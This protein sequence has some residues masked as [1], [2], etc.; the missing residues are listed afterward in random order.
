MN[1]YCK[2]CWQI[3]P[4]NEKHECIGSLR[5]ELQKLKNRVVEIERETL[6]IRQE[7]IEK[8]A[9][10]CDFTE[11]EFLADEAGDFLSHSAAASAICRDRILSQ[12]V[13]KDD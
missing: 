12:M 8:D 9:K 6:S 5:A 3:H 7:Q 2:Y 11:D 13:N 1:T 4:K 10:I